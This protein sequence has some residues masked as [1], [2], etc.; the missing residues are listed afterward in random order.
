LLQQELDKND[1]NHQLNQP[2]RVKNK[3]FFKLRPREEHTDTEDVKQLLATNGL[4]GWRS[5]VGPTDPERLHEKER[6]KELGERNQRCAQTT[7]HKSKKKGLEK[8][9][10]DERPKEK[11]EQAAADN[12]DGTG[13][14]SSDMECSDDGS[15][16]GHSSDSEDDTEVIDGNR[17]LK[18]TTTSSKHTGKKKKNFVCIVCGK[19]FRNKSNL[20]THK[21]IHKG[22]KLF[23]CDICGKSF[24]RKHSQDAHMRIHEEEK[25]FGCSVPNKGLNC[26]KSS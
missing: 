12:T 19:K 1:L 9:N 18:S 16:W 7:K 2:F 8:P 6:Q 24:T 26:K 10:L 11:S 14:D 5:R 20:R 4:R 22:E 25:P 21:T 23:G 13:T 3:D 17:E 15:W